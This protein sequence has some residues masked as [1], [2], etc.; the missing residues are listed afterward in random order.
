MEL[1]DLV[2]GVAFNLYPLAIFHEPFHLAV[3]EAFF[4]VG[5]NIGVNA[6]RDV[7]FVLFNQDVVEVIFNIVNQ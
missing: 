2:S 4:D 3:Y 5:F 6:Q 7:F 1:G